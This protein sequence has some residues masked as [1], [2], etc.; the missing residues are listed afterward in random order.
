MVYLE[1][2]SAGRDNNLNLI[3]M[4]A[5]TA[6]LVSHAWAIALGKGTVEPLKAETGVTLGTL[7]VYLFFVISGFLIA[8]SFARTRTVT[9]FVLARVLRLMPGLIASLLIVALLMG[10]L[11]T[12]L[13]T[14]AY[15]AHPDLWTFLVRNTLLA[16]PQYTLPGVFETQPYP[17][18]EGS[19]WT[20]VH[21]AAC[22]VGVLVLG[23]L[24]VLG[25]RDRMA[26]ALIAYALLWVVV[27]V[28]DPPLHPK[29]DAFWRLSL[30]FA[31]GMAFWR[32]QEWI[33]L[34]IW[35]LAGLVGLA[36]ALRGT[37]LYFFALIIALGYGS[38]WLAY[39][40]GGAIRAYN[41]IGDYSY[42]IYIYAFPMQGLAVWLAGPMSPWENIAIALPLTALLSI[43]SWHL[44]EKPA[45]DARHRLADR[46]EGWR[47]RRASEGGLS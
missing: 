17:T 33:P 21:E 25:R 31:A 28:Y 1:D 42:G 10:P 20:L 11:V 2:V 29:I 8:G 30:P 37:E 24:G 12:E 40:P 15:F 32:W 45:L 34:N 35:G 41:R 9:R 7:A 19:I 13:E 22:Y 4:V 46:I 5:A 43:P 27:I 38:F 14:P 36:V 18:V 39:I 16:F 44:I 26:L 3:R 6:V 23:L 47:G